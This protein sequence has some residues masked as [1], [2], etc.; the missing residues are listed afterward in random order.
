LKSAGQSIPDHLLSIAQLQVSKSVVANP[1]PFSAPRAMKQ[2][3]MT[4]GVAHIMGKRQLIGRTKIG[5]VF[6]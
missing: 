1:K 3:S 2:V 6:P 4:S 5:V